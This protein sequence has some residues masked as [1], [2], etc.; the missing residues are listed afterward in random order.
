MARAKKGGEYGANGEW[1]KGG[2]FLNTVA[3]NPK[4]EGS[5]NSKATRKQQVAPYQWELPPTSDHF[6]IFK[7]VGT[8]AAYVDRYNPERGIEPFEPGIRHYGSTFR[9]HEVADL[10]EAYNRGERWAIG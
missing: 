4:K 3:E 6:A 2:R 1:Y 7:I 10:C 9:G 5:S 8:M